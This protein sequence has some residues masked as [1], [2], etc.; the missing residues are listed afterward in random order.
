MK[1]SQPAIYK[2]TI[3]YP[4]H[5][6]N[7]V[8]SYQ[9]GAQYSNTILF[10]PKTQQI[11]KK[12]H[13]Q[14]TLRVFLI[15]IYFSLVNSQTKAPGNHNARAIAAAGDKRRE[16]QA[17]KLQMVL[18]LLLHLSKRNCRERFLANHYACAQ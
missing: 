14:R 11:K 9:L 7:S 12:K 17:R 5:R 10:I 8:N 18:F 13:D 16:K 15:R 2:R 6:L 3:L 1:S 4:T